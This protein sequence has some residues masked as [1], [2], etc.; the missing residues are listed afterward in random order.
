MFLTLTTYP[1]S[2]QH[3]LKEHLE[4][5]FFLENFKYTHEEEENKECTTITIIRNP[6]ESIA[7]W[8][9]MQNYYDKKTNHFLI[10]KN[11]K[12]CQAKYNKFYKYILSNVDIIIDYNYL[13]SNTEDIIQYI[14]QKIKNVPNNNNVVLNIK[15]EPDRKHI[16]SSKKNQEYDFILNITKKI[17]M[18]NEFELYN[19]ALKKS[20]PNFI[21]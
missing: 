18:K 1:R 16:V 5:R 21:L 6:L 12:F 3:F 7:S 10:I 19:L 4:Q 2:G 20:Y 15:D 9:A 11:I 13:N 8:V 14:G 17:D